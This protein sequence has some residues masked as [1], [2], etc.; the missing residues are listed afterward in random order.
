MSVLSDPGMRGLLR[1]GTS[2]YLEGPTLAELI[3]VGIRRPWL[4]AA[5]VAG[6]AVLGYGVSF[7]FTPQYRATAVVIPQT[8]SDM[9]RAMGSVTTLTGELGGLAAL[10]G[11][12]SMGSQKKNEAIEVLRARATTA[13][14]INQDGLMPILYENL[15]DKTRNNWREGVRV[16]SLPEAVDRFAKKVRVITEDR[17]TGLVTL[18]ITWRDPQL[19]SKW[20]TDMI[21]L[22]NARMRE[23]AEA[24]ADRTLQYLDGE[25]SHTQA[26]EMQTVLYRLVATQLRK[27]LLAEVRD[28]YAFKVIDPATVPD[29]RR[30]DFPNRW[31]FTGLGAV[32]GLIAALLVAMILAERERRRAVLPRVT[33]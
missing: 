24:E 33:P 21:A 14:L 25:I 8:D 12:D 20:A 31:L 7:L 26:M 23:S 9:D 10:A 13:Q 11:L 16:P 19:A 17:R 2:G 27:K 1:A 5:I 6:C 3:S 15:W 29:Y 4:V 18:D 22:V 30:P 28:D 32:L